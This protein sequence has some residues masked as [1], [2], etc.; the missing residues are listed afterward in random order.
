MRNRGNP[1]NFS[2]SCPKKS[3][4]FIPGDSNLSTRLSYFDMNKGF[5]FV[6]FIKCLWNFDCV[7]DLYLTLGLLIKVYMSEGLTLVPSIEIYKKPTCV[8]QVGWAVRRIYV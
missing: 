8:Y 5:M 4:I 7:K 3:R 6:L 1:L 2:I